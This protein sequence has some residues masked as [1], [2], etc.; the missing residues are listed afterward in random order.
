MEEQYLTH[1]FYI[2]EYLNPE[3]AN[4]PVN[5]DSKST[6]ITKHNMENPDRWTFDEA[7]VSKIPTV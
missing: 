3:E 6:E 1:Y 2:R 4:V 7:A 5:I